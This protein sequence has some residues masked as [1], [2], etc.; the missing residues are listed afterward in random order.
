MLCRDFYPP[1]CLTMI[2][3]SMFFT[4]SGRAS[5]MSLFERGLIEGGDLLIV[6]FFFHFFMFYKSFI[7]KKIVFF[8]KFLPFV[9]LTPNFFSPQASEQ[10]YLNYLIPK[11]DFNLLNRFV[12]N[13]SSKKFFT[14]KHFFSFGG[15][16]SQLLRNIYSEGFPP[17]FFL[18]K[19]GGIWLYRGDFFS[20]FSILGAF[21]LFGF[22]SFFPFFEN[23]RGPT[24]V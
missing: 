24:L 5:Q 3:E 2:L 8:L 14:R 19:A 4:F 20:D 15:P 6:E 10:Y 17:P 22:I 21:L 11:T 12:E 1:F 9:V 13:F 18:K 7:F 23:N 16:I